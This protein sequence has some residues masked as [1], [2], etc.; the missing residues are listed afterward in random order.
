MSAKRKV[1]GSKATKNVSAKCKVWGSK[2]FKK[3]SAKHDAGGSYFG[4]VLLV[5]YM[6]V[7][8]V[9]SVCVFVS[10]FCLSDNRSLLSVDLSK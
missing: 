3:T 4:C 10:P 2:A 8:L 6:D 7:G 5:S 1:R 9:Q